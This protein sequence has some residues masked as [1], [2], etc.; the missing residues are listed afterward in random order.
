MLSNLHTC[1]KTLAKGGGGRGPN[2][3]YTMT[4]KLI[5]FRFGSIFFEREKK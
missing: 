5:L 1:S 2:V 3:P 4:K